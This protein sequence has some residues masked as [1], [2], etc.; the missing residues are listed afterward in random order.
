M[1]AAKSDAQDRRQI[2]RI[3]ALTSWA[4]TGNRTARTQPARDAF[5]ARFERQVDPEG[6]LS[7]T[8]R[9]KRA[10]SAKQAYF[11]QLALKSAKA[12]RGQR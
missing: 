11:A 2:A 3:G 10:E 4:N 6:R 8:E 12:R 5:M 9:R 1:S 7:S